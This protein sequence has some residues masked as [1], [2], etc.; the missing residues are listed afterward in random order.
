MIHLILKG[1]GLGVESFYQCLILGFDYGIGFDKNMVNT[2]SIFD[3]EGLVYCLDL[4]HIKKV[5]YENFNALLIIFGSI[6]LKHS[7]LLMLM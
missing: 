5:N 2:G 4:N 7:V 6:E 1:Q 3:K